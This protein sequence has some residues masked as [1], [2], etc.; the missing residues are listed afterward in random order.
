MLL[1]YVESLLTV[2]SYAVSYWSFLTK[3]DNIL[4]N[5]SKLGCLH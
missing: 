1:H 5:L 2:P 3:L 4:Q